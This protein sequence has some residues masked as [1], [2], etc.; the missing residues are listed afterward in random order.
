MLSFL[1]TYTLLGLRYV[2][3]GGGNARWCKA[4][5]DTCILHTRARA[6]IHTYTYITHTNTHTQTHSHK[7]TRAHTQTHT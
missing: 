5:E 1:P 2:E 3:R 4:E 7:H 6:Y